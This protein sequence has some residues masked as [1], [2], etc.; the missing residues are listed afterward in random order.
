V[1]G[2]AEEEL[3]SLLSRQEAWKSSWTWPSPE[4]AGGMEE[5]L[6]ATLSLPRRLEAWRRT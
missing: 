3:L 5:D 1:S 2:G 6:V 4:A